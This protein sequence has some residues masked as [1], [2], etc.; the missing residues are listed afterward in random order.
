MEQ[1]LKQKQIK[2][3]YARWVCEKLLQ[4]GY[5][6]IET[7]PNP[8]RPEL[9]CWGF[10]DTPGFEETLGVILGGARNG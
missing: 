5:N 7:Y 1:K 2:I 8:L 6:P 3:I 10:E 4:N 9:L